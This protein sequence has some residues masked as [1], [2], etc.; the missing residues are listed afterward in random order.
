[1]RMRMKLKHT[2]F[3]WEIKPE[4]VDKD[5]IRIRGTRLG[6]RYKIAN[7]YFTPGISDDEARNNACLIASAPEML[8]AL[9]DVR[10]MAVCG[11]LDQFDGEPWLNAVFAVTE[12]AEGDAV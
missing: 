7:V 10:L 5:Y 11:Y 8:Q 9:K 6:S 1:M 4:E 3:P 12:K 2:D